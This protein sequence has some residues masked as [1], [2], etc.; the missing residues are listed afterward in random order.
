MSLADLIDKD[1]I[2]QVYV[3][4]CEIVDAKRFDEMTEVF[5][6]DCIGD[7]TQALGPGVISPDRA[8]LIASMHANLGEGSNCSATHH[9]VMN[10]RIRIDGDRATAKVNYY[11]VHRGCGDHEGALYS[12]WGQYADQLVRA[13]EGWRIARRVYTCQLTEGPAGVVSRATAAA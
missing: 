12:M 7:Y 8:S 10:F 9:N 13:P 2:Q 5:T 4:Y 11:A 6:A 1:A 3:R